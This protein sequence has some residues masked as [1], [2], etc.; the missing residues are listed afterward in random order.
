MSKSI[1]QSAVLLI[2]FYACTLENGTKSEPELY[3]EKN[4]VL[5]INGRIENTE[6]YLSDFDSAQSCKV[7][8]QSHYDEW[9]RSMH[10]FAMQDPIFIKGWLKRFPANT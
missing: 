8:H 3:P 1:L 2:I 5:D 10:A 9:S 7:C 6:M 4:Y